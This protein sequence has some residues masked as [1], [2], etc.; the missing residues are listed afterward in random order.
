V[1]D[2][3]WLAFIAKN[4]YARSI[5]HLMTDKVNFVAAFIFYLVFIGG[6]TH[7][8][9]LPAWQ[10]GI[11]HRVVFNAALFGFVT[12]ATYDLTNLATLKDWPLKVTLIDLIWGMFIS[13]TVSTL[14]LW[15]SQFFKG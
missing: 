11:T 4:L 13:T 14:T 1:I 5:G 6:L 2:F 15:F 9:T 10:E 3:I 7:F 12:Y 8:V